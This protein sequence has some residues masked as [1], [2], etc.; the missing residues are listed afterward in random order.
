MTTDEKDMPNKTQVAAKPKAKTATTDKKRL[1]LELAPAAY[2]LLQRLADDSGKSL[3]DV[4][5]TGLALYGIAQ[6]AKQEGRGIG[7]IE[8][9]AVVK[10]ILL[11]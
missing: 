10:E 3:A 6:D 11:T 8:G 4:L 7:V 2:E 5:R 1:N 9:D